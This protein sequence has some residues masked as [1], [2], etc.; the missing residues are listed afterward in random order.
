MDIMDMDDEVQGL[1]ALIDEIATADDL[2][3][4]A[5]EI[6]ERVERVCRALEPQPEI[7]GWEKITVTE[8]DTC[9]CCGR[10]DSWE[11]PMDVP[12]YADTDPAA[13]LQARWPAGFTLYSLMSE[14]KAVSLPEGRESLAATLAPFVPRLVAARAE[15][16]PEVEAERQYLDHV[17]DMA[18]AASY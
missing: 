3:D 8:T 10:S 1:I 6:R 12:V 15:I 5:A 7:V 11:I 18:D 14:I 16:A 9:A 2:P 13:E 4:V 17:A